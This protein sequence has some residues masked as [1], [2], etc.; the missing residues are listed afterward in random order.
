[1]K[2]KIGKLFRWLAFK[3]EDKCPPHEWYAPH[4]SGGTCGCPPLYCLKCGI[5]H[6]GNPTNFFHEK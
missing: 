5:G 1:M 2:N 4:G 3:I 6:P